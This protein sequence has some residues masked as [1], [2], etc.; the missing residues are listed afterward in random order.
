MPRGHA[1]SAVEHTMPTSSKDPDAFRLAAPVPTLP[2]RLNPQP[3][4]QTE[5]DIPQAAFA[6]PAVD[7]P[8]IVPVEVPAVAATAGRAA[9]VP[10]LLLPELMPVSESAPVMRPAPVRAAAGV[11]LPGPPRVVVDSVLAPLFGS[12][13]HSPVEPPVSWMVLAAARR[14]FGMP[15]SATAAPEWTVS[16]GQTRVV[17]PAAPLPGAATTN[18]PPVITGVTVGAPNSSTGVV[19]ATVKAS[20]P[21]GD[22]LTYKATVASTAKG[23]VAI[24]TAGVF[25]YAPTATARHSAAKVGAPTA[26]K[27][28]TVT[29]TVTD[30]KGAATTSAVIVPVLGK[31]ALPTQGSTIVA[32]PNTST[33]VV[34]GRVT[35]TDTDRDTLTY[36]APATTAKGAVSIDAGSGA[37]TY[38]PTAAAR[39]AAAIP[40]GP[41]AGKSDSFTVTVTD[42]YGGAL[43]VPVNVTISPRNSAPTA[44]VVIGKPD[45]VSG[46]A[47]GSVMA[48]DADKDNLAYAASKPAS[49]V[50]A[51]KADG[52]FSYTPTAA[53][54]TAA[55]TSSTVKTDAFTITVADGHGGST[56]VKVTA[57]IAPSN[58]APVAG[59]TT[60]GIPSASTGVVTGKVSATDPDKD[61]VTFTAA[62]PSTAKGNVSV[63]TAGAFTYT[64]TAG[65]RHAAARLGAP[66]V[67]KADSFTVTATDKYGGSTAIPVTVTIAPANTAPVAGTTTV[68]APNVST[69]VVTGTVSATD[70]DKDTLTFT[71][72]TSTAKGA[73]TINGGTG[74]F[75]YTPTAT[76]RRGAAADLVDGFTVTVADGYG[77]SVA[78]PVSVTIAPAYSAPAIQVDKSEP[79][80]EIVKFSLSGTVGGPVTW[81]SDLNT[82]GQGNASDGYS[83]S[84]NTRGVSNGDH[85][86]LARIQTGPDTY[87][88]VRR[89][90]TVA[91]P[92]LTLSTYTQGT[93][94]EILVD[95]YASSPEGIRS[96]VALFDGNPFGTLTQPNAYRRFSET[97]DI[98]RFTVNALEAGS[99]PH[100]MMITATDGSGSSRTVTVSVPINNPPVITLNTPDYG[101]IVSGSVRVNGTATIDKPGS[102]KTTANL[103][104]VPILTTEATNFD[105]SYSLQGLPPGRYTLSVT[106]TDSTGL[107]SQLTR[108]IIV[109][110]DPALAY[111]PVFTLPTVDAL[112]TANGSDLL[113]RAPDGSIRLRDLTKGSETALEDTAALQNALQWTV[114]GGR[115][116]AHGKSADCSSASSCTYEWTPAGTRRNLT[117]L[118]G[119]STG[120]QENPVARDGYV[121]C[122]NRDIGKPGSYTLYDVAAQT[123]TRITPPASVKY[124][125]NTRYDFAV[126][127]KVVHFWY[128]AQTGGNGTSSAFDIYN[129]RSDTAQTTRVTSDGNQNTYLEVDQSRVAWLQTTVG[130]PN[131]DTI[132]LLSR[133]LQGGST[134]TLATGV[135]DFQLGDGVLAWVENLGGEA[136]SLKAVAVGPVST[137]SNLSTASL[138]GVGGGCVVYA[139]AGKTYSW[140]SVSGA[141]SLLLDTVPGKIFVDG[142]QATFTVDNAVYRISLH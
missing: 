74:A 8:V 141:K 110:S 49:G 3:A 56:A 108:Q 44:T 123:F 27:T 130:A 131:G 109:T 47:K 38:T 21:D 106:S 114:D 134:Q 7:S 20:D 6:A 126:V 67:D 117:T 112:L 104:S 10:T 70:A 61:V 22:K 16:T 138:L 118:G 39:H 92:T 14:D 1:P 65:A 71:A 15:L 133:S 91:N 129:W 72:P 31:N 83:V 69:G 121:I 5:V 90:V 34:T 76:A 113:Y 73:V 93:R 101:A 142:N 81:Y 84:W 119:I 53:A 25:T 96:V 139:E 100:Q 135:T 125:G 107:S 75:T 77:A 105:T 30:A 94:G 37:F 46:V 79:L 63:T 64:P 85:Q 57:T 86:I 33:G 98:Y 60:V 97:P 36:G 80:S 26:A 102:V 55:R 51:V 59:T 24:T 13:P 68:G 28:D 9:A 122:T 48:S 124:V 95:V 11:V 78:I 127:G 62:T 140:N 111:T 17:A 58:A 103:G 32:A 88:E 66:A 12:G 128:W 132:N 19:S 4:A 137:L 115:V 87:G 136:R 18:R 42:G 29:V 35:A 99:G 120:Y 50:V 23:A 41:A 52:T 82:I 2:T 43:A 54:R 116:Y 89:T 40:G 45:P